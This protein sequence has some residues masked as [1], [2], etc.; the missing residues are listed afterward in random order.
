MQELHRAQAGVAAARQVE[1]GLGRHVAVAVEAAGASRVARVRERAVV[2]A[3]DGLDLALQRVGR[4]EAGPVG[5]GHVAVKAPAGKTMRVESIRL[6]RNETSFT[7]EAG[8]EVL[9][10]GY[11]LPEREP[12]EGFYRVKVAGVSHRRDELQQAGFDPGS[13]LA[14][15]PEPDNPHDPDA[16]GVWDAAAGAPGRVPPARPRPADRPA[17]PPRRTSRRRSASGSGGR[18]A[19]A[20]GSRSRS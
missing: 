3:E 17:A 7:G 6:T 16:V 20:S 8:D 9:G 11:W 15:V 1:V 2:L 4:G 14:L 18:A 10:S 12:P 19:A 5:G 13:E